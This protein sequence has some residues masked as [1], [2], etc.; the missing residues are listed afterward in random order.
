MGGTTA[1]ITRRAPQSAIP[2][3]SAA[4]LSSSSE[5]NHYVDSCNGMAHQLKAVVGIT[6]NP[7]VAANV[8]DGDCAGMSPSS[9][10]LPIYNTAVN[11]L[12]Y[13]TNPALTSENDHVG[14]CEFDGFSSGPTQAR[15]LCYCHSTT[16]SN[17]SSTTS[18]SGSSSTGAGSMQGWYLGAIGASCDATCSAAGSGL[19][20]DV[21]ALRAVAA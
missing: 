18:N 21:A 6:R 7:G 13:H 17:T 10:N 14:R 4:L 12:Y 5:K 3:A 8:T 19:S 15:A 11:D 16:T 9:I 1:E 2:S 20:C